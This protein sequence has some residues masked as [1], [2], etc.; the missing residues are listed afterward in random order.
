MQNQLIKRYNL[1]PHPEGGYYKEVYRSQTYVHSSQI[2]TERHS[3]THIYF[4]LL[5]GQV[6]KFHKVLHDEIW[7]FYEGHPLRLIQYKGENIFEKTLGS[8]KSPEYVGVVQGGTYQ[9]AE[10]LGEYSLVG[11]TVAPGFDFSDFSFLREDHRERDFLL[12]H[13][14]QFRHFV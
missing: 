3:I 9:A 7:N 5:K 6:S 8:S 14:P 4:L 12:T 2:N 1:S 10:P 11:C 13:F